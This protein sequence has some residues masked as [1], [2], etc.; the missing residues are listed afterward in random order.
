MKTEKKQLTYRDAVINGGAH[1]DNIKSLQEMLE[2]VLETQPQTRKHQVRKGSNLIR[3]IFSSYKHRGMIFGRLIQ[4][5]EG[6]S[7]PILKLDEITHQ[8]VV[9]AIRP[10][11]IPNNDPA[12]SAEFVNSILYFGVKENHVIMLTAQSLSSKQFELHLDWLFKRGIYSFQPIKSIFLS[13]KYPKDTEE[14]IRKNSVRKVRIGV[15]LGSEQTSF[16]LD[17]G[18]W[19]ISEEESILDSVKNVFR[20]KFTDIFGKTNFDRA[21]DEANLRMGLSLSIER[22]TNKKGQEFIDSMAISFRHSDENETEIELSDGSV[23]KGRELDQREDIVVQ[24]DA[25]GLPVPIDVWNGMANWLVKL[26]TSGDV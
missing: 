11:S 3:L 13:K 12:D 24:V 5:D 18:A 21:L 8:Y 10:D 15:P 9:S 23:L 19:V 14:L 22:G 6:A 1:D 7:Q 2:E 4:F 20:D 17:D 16:K 26:I 25:D